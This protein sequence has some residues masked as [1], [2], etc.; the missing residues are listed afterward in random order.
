M[1]DPLAGQGQKLFFCL[2]E[3][4]LVH[5]PPSL[6]VLHTQMCAHVKDPISICRQRVALTAGGMETRKHCTY[7]GKQNKK[8]NLGSAVLWLLAFPRESSPIFQCIAI[9]GQERYLI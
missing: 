7:I 1:F 2:S 8:E 4:T 9:L 3:S 5:P 6:C